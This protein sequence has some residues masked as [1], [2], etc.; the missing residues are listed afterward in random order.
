MLSTALVPKILLRHRQSPC[1]APPPS[2]PPWWPVIHQHIND[3]DAV[4]A[5]ATILHEEEDVKDKKK[6]LERLLLGLL[7]LESLR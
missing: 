4:I 1:Q 5:G 7:Q 3:K 2:T 6:G